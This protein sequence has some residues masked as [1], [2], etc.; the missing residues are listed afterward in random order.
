[1]II[2]NLICRGWRT[3]ATEQWQEGAAVPGRAVG[4]LQAEPAEQ[5]AAAAAWQAEH[6]AEVPLP[7]SQWQRQPP[8]GG[9]GQ[10]DL[11]QLRLQLRRD[12]VGLMVTGDLN[13]DLFTDLYTGL[14]IDLLLISTLISTDSVL[15]SILT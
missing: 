6:A 9:A 2:Y 10:A 4:Q 1:M 14:S 11:Q 12:K 8:P 13:T 3:E 7:A 5:A 15:T